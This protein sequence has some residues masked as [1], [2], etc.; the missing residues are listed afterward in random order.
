MWTHP[1]LD[2]DSPHPVRLVGFTNGFNYPTMAF[3]VTILAEYLRSSWASLI[4]VRYALSDT[5][6]RPIKAFWQTARSGLGL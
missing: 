6:K 2:H 5:K 1:K 4:A 3:F